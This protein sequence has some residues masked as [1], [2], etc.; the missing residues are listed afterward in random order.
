MIGGQ[1]LIYSDDAPISSVKGCKV[2]TSWPNPGKAPL[3][4][5]EHHKKEYL[6][7]NTS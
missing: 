5:D 1:K 7:K 4:L 2:Q 3:S 6:P